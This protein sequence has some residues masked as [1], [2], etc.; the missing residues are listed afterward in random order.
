MTPRKLLFYTHALGG[1]GAE[2]VFASL[3]S[4]MAS[5]GH[6]VLFAVDYEADENKS[7][8]SSNV[9]VFVLGGNHLGAINAL[10]RLLR[11]EKPDAALSALSLCN[12]KLVLA[13]IAAGYLQRSILSYHGYWVSEPQFLSRISYSLTPLLTRVAARTICVSEGLT[14]Y[15][16]FHF[17]AS[18]SRTQ[19]IYNPVLTGPL[20][21]AASKQELLSRP[22]IILA[23]GRM[24]SYKNLPFLI[25]A[26]A[27][28]SHRD[29]ELLIMGQGPER[30]AIETE[31]NQQG[32]GDR[33]KLLGY[34]AEPW[35]V[36][37]RARCFVLSSDSE[38]FG[39]VVA[40]A[41]ANGLSIVSTNCDG[42]REILDRG[43]YGWLVPPRDENQLASALDAA[44]DD[45]GDPAPRIERA[46]C[47]S[48]ERAVAAYEALI[49]EVI[50]R[51]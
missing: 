21:P 17:G 41:L 22:P 9:R 3:A 15:L 47:F 23:S 25:R 51:A 34:V 20:T 7:F 26:F 10:A 32:L 28:M 37:A 13:A 35:P 44:L 1:G 2:R 12:L 38:A 29:A 18:P 49:E 27:L 36:Y 30:A 16:K 40:E 45:P 5:L 11:T 6:E 8:L 42:P 33:V 43:R 14:N 24:V 46:E 39:L 19:L 4:S 48:L 50:A 31:I